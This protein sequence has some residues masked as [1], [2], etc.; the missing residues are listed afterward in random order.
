MQNINN[1]KNTWIYIS[2]RSNDK[3]FTLKYEFRNS[4]KSLLIW[5]FENSI[6]NISCCHS[7]KLKKLFDNS[8]S[9]NFLNRSFQV[10]PFLSSFLKSEKV[11]IK[12]VF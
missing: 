4:E 7:N 6:F 5:E 10:F 9:I 3:I 8:V 1:L 12:F 2:I 11:F